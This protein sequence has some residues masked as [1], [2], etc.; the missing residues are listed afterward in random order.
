MEEEKPKQPKSNDFKNPP[1]EVMDKINEVDKLITKANQAARERNRMSI[2][3]MGDRK[4]PSN[5]SC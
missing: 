4:K 1:K 3:T 5:E 2:N